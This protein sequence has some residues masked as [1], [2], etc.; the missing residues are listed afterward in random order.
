M[1]QSHQCFNLYDR[2][3][4]EKIVLRA[5]FL[6]P[7]MMSDEACFFYPVRGRGRIFSATESHPVSGA[8]ALVMKCGNYLN[9]FLENGPG[10]N[11]EVIAVHFHPKVLRKIYATELPTFLSAPSPQPRPPQIQKIK[12]D[13]LLSNYIKSLQFYFENPALVS[14]ELLQLKLKELILLLVKTKNADNIQRLF[15]S[16]FSPQE[17]SFKQIVEG[18]IFSNLNNEQLALLTQLSL[19]SFKREFERVYQTSPAKFFKQRKL[20]RAA[21]LLRGTS[22]RIGDIAFECGFKELSHFSKSFQQAYGLRP[23]Q[24]R[25]KNQ[26][27]Q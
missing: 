10:D 12:A 3:L 6:T 25:Q 13:A 17:Y 2:L 27:D 4:L 19:S 26:K 20:A 15:V 11:C 7:G 16:L 14:D 5:P 24:Y 22:L 8:E 23:S 1:I 18:H 9:H 21:E